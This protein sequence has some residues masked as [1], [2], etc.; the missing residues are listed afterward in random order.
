MQTI[1]VSP[2]LIAARA[3]RL[4]MRVGLAEEPPA[5]RVADDHVLGAGLLD[6]RRRH[7]AGERALALPVDVLRRHADV[8]VARG[9]GHGVHGRER[10]RD[11]DLD[12]GDVLDEGR[13]SF[14]NTTASCTVL[15]IFQLPAMNGVRIKASGRMGLVGRVG[16]VRRDAIHPAAWPA[17]MPRLT[18]PSAPRRP[19][20]CGRR[21]TRATR[22][23]RSRC[24]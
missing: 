15:N 22:R 18:S 10:R 11:D 13:S 6:H 19:A 16:S 17:R 1:G 12:V 7:L 5:L 3:F 8:R 2:A 23:R 24:A 4:T 21:E 14:T 9:L 20:A